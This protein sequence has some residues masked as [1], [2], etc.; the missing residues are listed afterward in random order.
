M[1][2]NLHQQMYRPKIYALIMITGLVLNDHSK[3]ILNDESKLLKLSIAF[4]SITIEKT[5][6]E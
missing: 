6:P 1:A 2:C 4:L 5:T 3:A